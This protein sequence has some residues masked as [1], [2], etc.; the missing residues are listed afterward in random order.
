M[1][2]LNEDIC[3]EQNVVY[4]IIILVLDECICIE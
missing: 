3:I 4:L 1:S 2:A